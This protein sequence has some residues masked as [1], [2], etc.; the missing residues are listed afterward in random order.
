MDVSEYRIRVLSFLEILKIGFI[1][2]K[3]NKKQ[4]N[5]HTALGLYNLKQI[6]PDIVNSINR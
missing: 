1:L 4:N 6:N 2:K 5:T 3:D